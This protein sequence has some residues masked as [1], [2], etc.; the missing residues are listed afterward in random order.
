MVRSLAKSSSLARYW[1][2][3]NNA[4]LTQKPRSLI[5]QTLWIWMFPIAQ[6][7]F[8]TAKQHDQILVVLYQWALVDGPALC[9]FHSRPP[10]PFETLA[11]GTIRVVHN[12]PW[13]AKRKVVY[14]NRELKGVKHWSLW[15][16]FQ[17]RR[18]IGEWRPALTVKEQPPG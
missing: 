1:C 17:D 15:R 12:V 6:E 3:K 9:M 2:E 14:V 16:S 7:G 18:V 10:Y 13:D 5:W 11:V 4:S 8:G